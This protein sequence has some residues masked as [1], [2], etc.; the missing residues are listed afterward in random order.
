M[1]APDRPM[2]SWLFAPASH[3]GRMAKALASPADV[4]VL[5][6]EDACAD[7]Q[8]DEARAMARDALGGPR[9]GFGPSPLAY[10]RIN[11]PATG[12]AEGDLQ[13]LVCAGLD[14]V[15]VPK[16]E[17]AEDL[18]AVGE[19][20]DLLETR[21]G[22]PNGGIEIVPLVE[23]AAGLAEVRA[24]ASACLRVRRLA[25]GAVDF[26]LDLDLQPGPDELELAPF[27]AALVL[28]ARAAGLEPPIDSP[29]MAIDAPEQVTAAALRSRRAG[30]QG[31]LCIHPSQVEPVNAAFSPTGEELTRAARIVQAFE[32]AEADGAAAINL[33][34]E[35]V[36][37]P[38][39]RRARR[40]LASSLQG[41]V[42]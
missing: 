38:V 26:A 7:A 27:R 32:A 14:G 3:P 15:M 1:P 18:Q 4:T 35:L 5:D 9:R 29:A 8:K 31:K 16:A 37:Y 33:D 12:R 13:A 17:R 36:D 2:R 41:S 24:L 23:T 22:L 39:F 20:I 25:F 28:G 6:L 21:R 40:L 10:V 19:L 11:A 30:F 34:G 42:R